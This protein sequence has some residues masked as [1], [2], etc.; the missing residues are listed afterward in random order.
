MVKVRNTGSSVPH[1]Q[2]VTFLKKIKSFYPSFI[3]IQCPFASP[4]FLRL[5]NEYCTKVHRSCHER[6][7]FLGKFENPR[8]GKTTQYSWTVE[9]TSRVS[10]KYKTKGFEQ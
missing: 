9:M 10:L 4:S 5:I 1:S 8:G 7:L 2:V 3:C 6:Y